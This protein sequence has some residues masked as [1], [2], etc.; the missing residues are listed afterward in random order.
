[1][2][3][4]NIKEYKKSR[5]IVR[6]LISKELLSNKSIEEL[7]QSDY[8][9]EKIENYFKYIRLSVIEMASTYKNTEMEDFTTEI[10]NGIFSEKEIF[11]Q[12]KNIIVT[13]NDLQEIY[14][15]EHTDEFFIK[16]INAYKE[17]ADQIDDLYE[18]AFNVIGEDGIRAVNM[19]IPRIIENNN[20]NTQ[21]L[22]KVTEG[23]IQQA[24]IINF[25]IS[26]KHN[27][28]YDGNN[29]LFCEE[30]YKSY[31]Q[32]KDDEDRKNFW[33]IKNH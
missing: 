12:M 11:A 1:M 29:E 25:M 7:K 3:K 18:E 6:F 22:K 32:K 4:N 16:P 8:I 28:D 10:I 15:K 20:F 23:I 17:A 27:I 14:G 19:S 21:E 26:K 9:K 13:Y 24:R 2:E 5:A 30:L 31:K 33:T